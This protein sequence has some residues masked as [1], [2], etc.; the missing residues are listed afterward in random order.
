M[1]DTLRHQVRWSILALG[2]VSAL[3]AG[4]HTLGVVAPADHWFWNSFGLWSG[5][6][7]AA[8]SLGWQAAMLGACRI[9]DGAGPVT[10]WQESERHRLL[11]AGFGRALFCGTLLVLAEELLLRSLLLPLIG[12]LAVIA[13]AGALRWR[14]GRRATL[15]GMAQALLLTA[16]ALFT[17]NT[18]AALVAHL[19]T[20]IIWLSYLALAPWR[21]GFALTQFSGAGNLSEAISEVP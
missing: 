15:W 14:A 21:P 13:L 5:I 3:V 17:S 12:S 10:A 19:L 2:L 11:A 8:V 20:E 16:V 1:R 7:C 4:A 18:L 9:L 6:V